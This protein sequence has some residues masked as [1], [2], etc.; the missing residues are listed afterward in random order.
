[1]DVRCIVTMLK[2][3]QVYKSFKQGWFRRH[4]GPLTAVRNVSFALARGETLG[5]VGESG[6]GKSTLARLLPL[7]IRPD[8]GCVTLNGDALTT[9]KTKALMQA[10]RK[11]QLISQ[12]PLSS[13]NPLIRLQTSMMEPFVVTGRNKKI[14]QSMR[15]GYLEQFDLPLDILHRYPHQASGGELQRLSIARALM[16]APDYLILDEATAML[17]VS[18]QAKILH[19]L[20]SIQKEMNIGVLFI[21]HDLDVAAFMSDEL[22]IM[23]NGQFIE[24]GYCE[25]NWLF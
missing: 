3:T 4:G 1:M 23:R 7:L 20:K 10:R 22:A 5:I 2:V 13:F 15:Y 21:S 19:L 6:S 9:M 12:H 24:T 11:I 14:T 8:R 16:L 18:S 17:D 25:S